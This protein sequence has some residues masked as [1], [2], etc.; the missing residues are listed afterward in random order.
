MKREFVTFPDRDSWLKARENNIG[1]STLAAFEV[2]G[3][4]A[5]PLPRG[6]P[7]LEMALRFGSDWEPYVAQLF[8]RKIGLAD[9]LKYNVPFEELKDSEFCWYDN[10]FYSVLGGKVHASLDAAYKDVHGNKVIV[11]IK[12][13]SATRFGFV[14]KTMRER[15]VRQARMESLISGAS[16]YVIVYCHRP[17][18]WEN[19]QPEAIGQALHDSM[20]IVRYDLDEPTGEEREAL[21][22]DAYDAY[23]KDSPDKT[24]TPLLVKLV[25]AEAR[26]KELKS[27]ISD[28]LNGHPGVILSGGG[29][30]AQLKES[31]TIKTDYKKLVEDYKVDNLEDYRTVTKTMRMSITKE[32]NVK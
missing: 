27:E 17:S 24:E 1:A 3:E 16:T 15:Y 32:R 14:D 19:M 28:Y 7:A 9:N 4:H 21:I 29:K 6:I 23:M 18:G 13:G 10:S 22:K 8:A 20:D 26:V 30:M 2:T 11:E 12:T 25:E 5:K 31:E